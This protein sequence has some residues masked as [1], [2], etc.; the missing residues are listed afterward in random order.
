MYKFLMLSLMVVSFN[1]FAAQG[2]IVIK[3]YPLGMISVI[4]EEASRNNGLCYFRSVLRMPGFPPHEC[5]YVAEKLSGRLLG[6]C[7]DIYQKKL[8]PE[9]Q[10]LNFV[11][12]FAALPGQLRKQDVENSN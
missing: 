4:Q 10:I 6:L 1:V 7:G 11:G 2:K 8:T 12:I 3:D 9:G 5:G